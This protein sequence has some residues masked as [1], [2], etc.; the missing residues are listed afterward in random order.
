MNP[1]DC[2]KLTGECQHDCFICGG[3][4]VLP[5]ERQSKLSPEEI[6]ELLDRSAEGVKDLRH[7]LDRVFRLPPYAIRLS[8]HHSRR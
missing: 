4:G 2:T 6:D 1:C 8:S 7:T 5:I 3:E